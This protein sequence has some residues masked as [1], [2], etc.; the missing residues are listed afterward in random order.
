[1]ALSI[2]LTFILFWVVG[3]P[4][5]I[6][7]KLYIN[8]KNLNDNDFIQRYGL[9]FVGLNDDAFFWEVVILNARKIIFITCSTFFSS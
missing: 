5:F 1:M 6:F 8:R 3:F 2:G 7:I 4:A 9:F